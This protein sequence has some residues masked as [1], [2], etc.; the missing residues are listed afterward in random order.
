MDFTVVW[1]VAIVVVALYAGYKI[2]QRHVETLPSKLD[3]GRK[4]DYVYRLKEEVFSKAEA[5]CF[6]T[7]DEVFSKKFYV[8]PKMSLNTILDGEIKGQN[9]DGARQLIAEL[10]V[11][12]MLLHRKTLTPIC[13]VQLDDRIEGNFVMEQILTEV[14]FPIVKLKRPEEMSKREI[15]KEFAEVLKKYYD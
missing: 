7:L 9:W 12:F 1:I 8:V 15:V 14:G 13:A 10:K 2:M 11:D 6:E 5:R 4:K 3:F